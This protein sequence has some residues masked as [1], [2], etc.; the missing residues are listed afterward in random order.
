MAKLVFSLNQ[1]L[2]GFVDHQHFEPAP[3]L[4]RHWIEQVGQLAGSIYG[5]G[6]YEVMRYWDEDL[7]GWNAAE[8][9]FAAVWRRQPKWVVSRSLTSVGSNAT[10]VR[11]RMEAV[12]RELK[13][14]VDGEIDV[15]GPVLAASL[16]ALGLIDEYRLYVHPLVLGEGA[17]LFA[18]A[19]PALRLIANELIA[20]GVVRLSYA[21]A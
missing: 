14:A 18:G 11:D 3:A 4:F 16:G 20:D 6:M 17:P 12:V 7:A 21:P 1:S 19:R 5:R 15:S 9:E 10:L 2:D 8:R 13:T